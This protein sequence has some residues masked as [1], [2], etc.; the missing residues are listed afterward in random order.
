MNRIRASYH[1]TLSSIKIKISVTTDTPYMKQSRVKGHHSISM[2]LLCKNNP[3]HA[4]TAKILKTAD[5]T[6]VPIPRLFFVTNV[7]ITLIK[8]SGDDVD[9]AI[10]VA[11]ATS[12]RILNSRIKKNVIKFA[13]KSKIETFRNYFDTYPL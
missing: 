7:P 6:I 2:S 9:A 4:G 5:P 8:S 11:P 13:I 3:Q 1:I 10:I 12:L